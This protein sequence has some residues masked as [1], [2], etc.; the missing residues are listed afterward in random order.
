MKVLQIII[1][2]ALFQR[3]IVSDGEAKTAIVRAG[4]A[5]P[6]ITGSN[7]VACREGDK[8]IGAD[9][10]AINASS[11]KVSGTVCCGILK[12]CTIRF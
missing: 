10:E 5:K 9:F 4:F 7:W 12:G 8:M 11:Q 6:V 2:A 3:C 1:L